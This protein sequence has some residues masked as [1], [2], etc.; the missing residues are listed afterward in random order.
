MLLNNVEAVRD[1][2]SS[3][4]FFTL[5]L[6]LSMFSWGISWSSGK[7]LSEYA[8]A[9]TVSLFRFTLTFVSLL[10]LLLLSRQTIVI[11]NKSFGTLF[12]S[13]L[14]MTAYGYLFFKGLRLGKAG[15]GGVLVTTIN[16][17]ISYG[18]ALIRTKR[19]PDRNETIGILLGLIACIILLHVWNDWY[20]VF[21]IGNSYF[22]LSAFVWALL[23]IFTSKSSQFGSPVAFS[24]WL[25][26]GCS[27]VMLLFT[28]TNE[29]L[30][31]A[32]QRDMIFWANLF[33]SATITTAL[34]TTFYFVATTKLGANKASS[35]ILL[36]PVFAAI[37]SWIFLQEIPEWYTI[38]GG[39]IGILAVYI[40]NK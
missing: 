26:G 25:Y 23:S 22:L 30:R 16:P 10:V 34:A 18:I 29:C 20:A 13:I 32:S 4:Y 5:G 21:S 2:K 31:L 40:L 15:A 11:H 12:I 37:G 8:D 3:T 17:V 33:F 1:K 7:V 14:L 36:V 9:S 24:L 38:C 27:V 39:L 6:L 28:D 35:Y 19:L